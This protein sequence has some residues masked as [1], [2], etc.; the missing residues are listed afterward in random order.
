MDKIDNISLIENGLI[1]IQF[2]MSCKE[3]SYFRI[4]RESH[5][6]F[7]RSAIESL[8]GTANIAI[9]G[10]LSKE[11]SYKYRVGNDPYK[12][13]HK[14]KINECE[15]A[16]R[17]SKPEMCEEPNGQSKN[18]RNSNFLIGFYDTLAMVQTECFMKRYVHSKAIWIEDAKMKLFEWLHEEIR[19]EYEHFIPKL[20]SAVIYDLL[21]VS[22]LCMDLSKKI[23]FESGN[24]RIYKNGKRRKIEELFHKNMDKIERNL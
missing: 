9:T 13:I 17:F 14:V 16:W 22:N 2:E 18:K 10:Q 8:R 7:Y 12:E 11:R 6:I 24:I 21:Y 1:H 3:I 19:N 5:L 4:A 15:K 20:Y 23:I